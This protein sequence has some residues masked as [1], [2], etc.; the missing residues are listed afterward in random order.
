MNSKLISKMAAG[1]VTAAV[2][3]VPA[4]VATP[5][6][7]TDD[8]DAVAVATTATEDPDA[9][10]VAT[11]ATEDPEADALSWDFAIESNTAAKCR[12]RRREYINDGYTVS[13]C[14]RG[15]PNWRIWVFMVSY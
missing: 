8:P 6:Y 2:M 12:Q 3:V 10:A 14:G 1:L 15:N 4:A 5:A 9:V 7:A 13:S 11:P